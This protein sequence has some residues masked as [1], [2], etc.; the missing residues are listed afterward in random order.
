MKP[1]P[2]FEA[3]HK[4]LSEFYESSNYGNSLSGRLMKK[5][6]VV[7]ENSFGTDKFFET[8][9]E[10]GSGTGVHLDYIRH[11][12][13]TYYLTDGSDEMLDIARREVATKKMD[14]KI[15]FQKEEAG[16][17]SFS[18]AFCDRLIATHV[19]EHLYHPHEVLREWARVVKP[20]GIISLILPCDPG[21]AWR[22][23]RYAAIRG[24]HNAAG[25]PYDY[26]MAR[27]H[28]NP[29]N[30]L[31]SFIRYYFPVCE[32][33]WYPALIPSIDLNL[34]YICHIRV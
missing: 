28:V 13:G 30:N 1:D 7:C 2:D 3:Y 11:R 4:H 20:G 24:K 26:W 27:E 8:V 21:L 32:E 17:L 10:V 14:F 33:K 9:V 16:K 12:T 6:H 18:D 5:G 19:L 15:I 22:L 25:I 23:G 31:V 34:F 29:I